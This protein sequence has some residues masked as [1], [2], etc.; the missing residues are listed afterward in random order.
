MEN[1]VEVGKIQLEYDL[2][3]VGRVNSAGKVAREVYVNLEEVDVARSYVELEKKRNRRRRFI[4]SKLGKYA[5]SFGYYKPFV[6]DADDAELDK[7]SEYLDVYYEQLND[8]RSELNDDNFQELYRLMSFT[9][10]KNRDIRVEVERRRE[11]WRNGEVADSSEFP[12]TRSAMETFSEW[13]SETLPK[14]SY[15]ERVEKVKK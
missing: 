5:E 2:Y 14:A 1:I 10:K 7:K 3:E 13:F 8:I 6:Y 9:R 4:S 15:V 11:S 12:K